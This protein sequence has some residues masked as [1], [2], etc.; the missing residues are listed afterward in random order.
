MENFFELLSKVVALLEKFVADKGNREISVEAFVLWLTREILIDGEFGPENKIGFA[1]KHGNHGSGE[2]GDEKHDHSPSPDV[3]I[4]LLLHTLSKHFKKYSRKLLHDSDLVS[5]DGHL[6]L[7]TIYHIDSIRKMELIRANFNEVPS[8]IEVIN[9]LLQKGF[10]E[11]FDDADD[12]RSKRVR[13]TDKGRKEFD[14]TLP[15]LRQVIKVMAG[16]MD[17]EKKVMLVSLLDELNDFH[18]DLHGEAKNLTLDELVERCEFP[19]SE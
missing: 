14:A 2:P 10:I 7:S 15:P 4:T 16:N 18:I 13:I 1:R 17:T 11:E 8:G 5:M 3:R 19:G 6:F 12:R 9:R